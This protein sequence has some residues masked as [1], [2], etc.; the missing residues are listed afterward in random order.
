MRV[1]HQEPR[2][3]AEAWGEWCR[4]G[5]GMQGGEGGWKSEGEL[6]Q[7]NS[8]GCRAWGARRSPAQVCE[9]RQAVPG[10]SPAQSLAQVTS[11]SERLSQDTQCPQ[12]SPRTPWAWSPS[13]PHVGGHGTGLLPSR[14]SG[15]PSRRWEMRAAT[16][17]NTEKM[18]Y[19]SGR[20]YTQGHRKGQDFSFLPTLFLI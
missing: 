12:N 15:H 16:Y 6:E 2:A 13:S 8:C 14:L 4:E 11:G 20:S 17:T 5:R 18:R 7:A 19:K 1:G 3:E 9:N 10:L